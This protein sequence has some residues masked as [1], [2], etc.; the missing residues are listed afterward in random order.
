[1]NIQT[2]KTILAQAGESIS[3]LRESYRLETGYSFF[4][5]QTFAEYLVEQALAICPREPESCD[6]CGRVSLPSESLTTVEDEIF[7]ATYREK[8]CDAC[9]VRNAELDFELYTRSL[10]GNPG[11]Y[12]RDLDN[13][14]RF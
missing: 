14:A 6:F 12:D 3:G 11:G 4:R 7:G 8:M 13:P 10:A 2:A 1:M 5:N 9:F